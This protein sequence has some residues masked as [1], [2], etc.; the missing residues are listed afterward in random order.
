MKIK[1]I[2]A[3]LIVIAVITLAAMV[4][5]GKKSENTS[6]E[7]KTSSEGKTSSE[8]ETTSEDTTSSEDETSSA[9]ESSEESGSQLEGSLEDILAAVYAGAEGAEGYEL[10]PEYTVTTP[11]DPGNC[12]YYFGVETL[13]FKEGIA[14]EFEMGGAY[15]LCLI[16]ANS[17]D[18]VENLKETIAENVNPMKWVCMGVDADKVV[19][20][21]IGD[22]IILIMYNDSEFLHQSFLDL[23]DSE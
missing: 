15:S 20:D 18:D 5:C 23:A 22:V 6:S 4:S 16:R 12:F 1:K 13:D 17:L 14:S 19:V 3:L 8:E 2:I 7:D 11:I 21:N 9:V 10:D